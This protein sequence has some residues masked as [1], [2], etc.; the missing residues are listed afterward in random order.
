[1][2]QSKVAGAAGEGAL[3]D[4]VPLGV[5]DELGIGWSGEPIAPGDFAVELAGAPASITDR[6]QVFL[7]PLLAADVAQDL[8]AGGHC[9]GLVNAQRLGPLVLGAMHDKAAFGLYR[10]PEKHW[11][12]AVDFS[13]RGIGPAVAVGKQRRDRLLGDPAVDD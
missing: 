4:L 12:R 7:W 9:E 13:I 11:D 5:E 2:G 3:P 10:P 6:E 8:P 1:M